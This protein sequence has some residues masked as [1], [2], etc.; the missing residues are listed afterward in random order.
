MNA[1]DAIMLD[2]VAKRGMPVPAEAA[3]R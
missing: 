2:E 1:L 3:V